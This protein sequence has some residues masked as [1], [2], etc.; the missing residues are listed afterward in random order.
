MPPKKEGVG[1]L[2]LPAWRDCAVKEKEKPGMPLGNE[3]GV[4][5]TADA[6]ATGGAFSRVLMACFSFA[7]RCFSAFKV[8][9]L[10][11]ALQKE[12]KDSKA[13]LT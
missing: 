1:V 7:R 5:G 4:G 12:V 13:M 9:F 6:E 2:P 10:R 3:G 8:F 11:C